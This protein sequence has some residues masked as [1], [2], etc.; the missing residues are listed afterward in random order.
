MPTNPDT[1][2]QEANCFRCNSNASEADLLELALLDRISTAASSDSTPGLPLTSV[3]FND[4]GVFGG[5]A[6]LTWNKTTNLLS[7]VGGISMTAE[8]NETPLTISGYS[9]TGANAQSALS[10]AGTWNTSGTPTAID[11]NIT[12][13]ASNANSLLQN[14][15]VASSSVAFLRVDG[16]YHSTFLTTGSG[17]TECSLSFYRSGLSISSSALVSWS[18]GANASGSDTTLSRNAAGIVQCG[19]GATFHH[20]YAN[21]VRTATAYTVAT[22]PAAGTAGR[23]A[24]VTDAL[25]PAYGAA[26]A[27][28]GAV[29]IPVWDNGAA[30]ITV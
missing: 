12:N 1:L 22:L 18:N 26:V 16:R 14:W 28:G 15:R 20:L 25:A 2:F 19:S 3:Q 30:W 21:T 5:D 9:L 10:I 6:D 4:G 24:Y 11:L 8:A 13:T 17:N 23:Y 27:G 7:I 29:T